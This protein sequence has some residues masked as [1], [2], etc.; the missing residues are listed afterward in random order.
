MS[1]DREQGGGSLVGMVLEDAYRLTRLIGEG[2]MGSVYEATQL[3]LG[4]R[5]AVK[6]MARDLA[7]NQEALA[8]FRR[9]AEVTSQLGHPHIVHLNDFG[10]APSGEPYLVMECLDGEDLD[11]RIRRVGRLPL[12]AAVHIVKQVASALAATHAKGVVHRDLKPANVFLLTAEGETDFVKV[13][14]FG[15]SKAKAATTQLTRGSVV[16]GTPAYMSPEQATGKI[17]EIDHRTDQFALAC[18]TWEMLTGR[19]PF[20]GEDIASLLYQIIHQDP[21][22]LA[23]KVAGVPLAVEQVLLRALSKRQGTRFPTITAFSRTLEEAATTRAIPAG[24]K[25]QARSAETSHLPIR[26]WMGAALG[27]ARNAAGRWTTRPAP[28]DPS[29]RGVEE[30]LAYGGAANL[31][32]EPSDTVYSPIAEGFEPTRVDQGRSATGNARPAPTTFSHTASEITRPI[33]RFKRRLRSERGIAVGIGAALTIVVAMVIG[34]RA[35]TK[36]SPPVSVHASPAAPTTGP[37]VSPIVEKVTDEVTLTITGAPPG[38]RVL[39]DGVPGKIPI[40]L[41]RGSDIHV[42][43]FEAPGFEARQIKI[44]GG[45]DQTIAVALRKRQASKALGDRRPNPFDVPS[46]PFEKEPMKVAPTTKPPP[47]PQPRRRVMVQD[48]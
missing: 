39:V 27:W 22:L 34:G 6:L 12:A 41:P 29:P 28:E 48:L 33:E 46:N 3:K 13:L 17:D 31:Q 14:D 43:R 8:R 32:S 1:G 42:L 19:P 9:E 47:S 45:K 23:T 2:G 7:A 36:R 30:T 35:S 16:M 10:T 11:H 37:I 40:S 18:I 5:V 38:V 21:P 4:K 15:I 24:G 26:A 44:D 25:K 20:V